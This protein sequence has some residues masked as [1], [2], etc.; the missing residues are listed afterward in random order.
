M[1]EKSVAFLFF[2]RKPS[3]FRKGPWL[4]MLR[5]TVDGISKELSLK[6]T[7]E[8]SR[9]DSGKQRAA[10]TKED[11]KALNVYLDLILAKAQ[12]ARTKM[13]EKDQHITA[14]G[15]KDVLSGSAER[16]RM[17]GLVFQDH[18]K[19]MAELITKGEYSPA[20]LE[21]FETAK[22]FF[23]D[24]LLFKYNIGDVN[25]HSLNLEM[26]KAF[27]IWLRSKRNCSHNTATKYITN[28][29]KIVLLCVKH[30][31]LQNDPWALFDM[32]L[33]EVD[34]KFLT[35]EQLERI[36]HKEMPGERLSVV[37]DVFVFCCLTGLAYK[38]L[39]ALKSTELSIGVDG[40]IWIQKRRKKS[41]TAFKVPL[42]PWTLEIIGKYKNHPRCIATGAVLPVLSN[43]KYNDYLKEVAAICGIDIELTTHVARHTFATTVA[44]LNGITLIALRDMLGHK[45]VSQTEHYAKVLPIMIS[46]EMNELEKKLEN[47]LFNCEKR[48]MTKNY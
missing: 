19:E 9:W 21:R 5:I 30:G 38:D 14:Q 39:A 41:T 40:K 22:K 26:V 4:V 28:V 31:W 45:K 25:I 35:K 43:S 3:P 27:Y 11:A 13:I 36:I 42:L 46:T 12:A 37:R 1:L 29:K 47:E 15:I 24:F 2:L 8:T 44:L 32:T 20:T 34:T 33:E 6:R 10:G 7:W 16:R 48:T 23:F 18:N 17:F